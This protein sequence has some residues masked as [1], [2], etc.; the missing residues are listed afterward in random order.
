VMDEENLESPLMETVEKQS[1]ALLRHGNPGQ[2]RFS[3][4]S[5]AKC[6]KDRL[7]VLSAS[8]GKQQPGSWRFLTW[9]STHSQ[10]IPLREQ[11]S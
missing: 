3:M 10:Q 9:Y 6:S 8:F 5:F 4:T 7:Y 1:C 2:T 11:G